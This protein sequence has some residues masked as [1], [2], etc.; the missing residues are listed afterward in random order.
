MFQT[1]SGLNIA[2]CTTM[3]ILLASAETYGWFGKQLNG[4]LFNKESLLSSEKC[5][6]YALRCN[7]PMITKATP[8]CFAR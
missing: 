8:F 1:M 7:M 4:S 6:K 2:L 5:H 3:V